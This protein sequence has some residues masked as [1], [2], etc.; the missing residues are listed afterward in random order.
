MEQ[1][2]RLPKI[3]T[4][5]HAILGAWHCMILCLQKIHEQK[6]NII[7]IAANK[8]VP[9]QKPVC[10]NIDL[11]S[12]T[13]PKKTSAT[14]YGQ[15]WKLINQKQASIYSHLHKHPWTNTKQNPRNGKRAASE[16]LGTSAVPGTLAA[17][18]LAALISSCHGALACSLGLFG[19]SAPRF[20]VDLH[21][22]H[23]RSCEGPSNLCSSIRRWRIS[24]RGMGWR[25][26]D[27][28]VPAGTREPNLDQ[29]I[30]S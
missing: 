22:H 6:T 13:Q 4:W 8:F 14:T 2:T 17:A 9:W 30:I 29:L 27:T 19:G 18:A 26:T 3:Q 1:N 12:R 28:T 11:I 16:T 21:W 15:K 24:S 25:S 20:P 10:S 7:H 23:P 5:N